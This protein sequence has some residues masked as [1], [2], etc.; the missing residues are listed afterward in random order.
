[1]WDNRVEG[2]THV[3]KPILHERTGVLLV[4]PA[5]QAERFQPSKPPASR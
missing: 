4:E 5:G 3:S 1:M 2:S